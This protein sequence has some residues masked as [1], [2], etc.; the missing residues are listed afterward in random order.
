MVNFVNHLAN[1]SVFAQVGSCI[2]LA[3]GGVSALVGGY[4]FLLQLQQLQDR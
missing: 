4:G 2:I 3:S 1:A